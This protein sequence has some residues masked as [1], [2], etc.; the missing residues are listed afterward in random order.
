MKTS[1]NYALKYG[2][3]AG[4][5]MIV[6]W[7][8]SHQLFT[9]EDGSFDSSMGEFLGYAAMILAFTM[10]FLGVKNYRDRE[11]AGHITFGKAFLIG[12]Y[13]VLVTSVIYVVGWMIYYPNFMADFPDQYLQSQLAQLKESG[14]SETE[15]Q[16]KKEELIGW[17]EWYK[18][19]Q[20]MAAMT[21]M[22]IF[23]VGLIVTVISAFIWKKK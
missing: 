6:S 8:V 2:A 19:P 23:P 13:I 5:I 9:S 12:L 16:T 22:E 11:G 14:L 1:L 10:V 21:F 18:E 20:N 7:F 15:I 3:V 17:M 4:V